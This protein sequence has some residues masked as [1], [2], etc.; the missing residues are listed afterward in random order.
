MTSMLGGAEAPP[1]CEGATPAKSGPNEISKSRHTDSIQTVA[2]V[3]ARIVR[4]PA[5]DCDLLSGHGQIAA[6]HG[7]TVAQVRAKIA[8]GE[9]L[10]FYLPGKTTVYA[11]KSS[12]HK[13]WRQAEEAY[14]NRTSSLPAVTAPDNQGGQHEH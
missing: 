5:S 9:I 11:L 10:V 2:Q 14:L 4:L 12:Q 1:Q 8:A 3:Q 13:R 7:L 6:W